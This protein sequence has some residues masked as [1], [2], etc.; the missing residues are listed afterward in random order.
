MNQPDI[1]SL[2]RVFV[3]VYL[4]AVFV[5]VYVTV[6]VTVCVCVCEIQRGG[7]ERGGER[8]GRREEEKEWEGYTHQAQYSWTACLVQSESA[9]AGVV[10]H[11][12]DWTRL[13]EYR[14]T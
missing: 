6:Y 13:C 2:C 3:F 4:C 11:F 7:K 9:L 5:L 1:G 12:M 10:A 14:R 8:R